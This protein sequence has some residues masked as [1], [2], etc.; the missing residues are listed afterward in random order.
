[1]AGARRNDGLN[2]FRGPRDDPKE[3]LTLL[4]RL[5]KKIET[6][7]RQNP[8]PEF[9]E[10]RLAELV[11]HYADMLAEWAVLSMK[12]K[13]FKVPAPKKYEALPDGWAV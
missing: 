4:L 13:A 12:A 1:M 9:D 6:A 3:E 8:D 11:G 10:I 7:Q 5:I 2:P